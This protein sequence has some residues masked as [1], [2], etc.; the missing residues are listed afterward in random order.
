MAIES[1]VTAS[2]ES[3]AGLYVGTSGWSYPSW[4]PGFYP[5]GIDAREFL[6]FY[7]Q[8]FRTVELNTTGYR[9]P[10][11]EQFERWAAAD[12]ASPSSF[13]PS[14]RR[15]SPPST[16]GCGRSATGSGPSASQ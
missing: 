12:S 4:R 9:L 13:P 7:A 1:S 11:Q 14:G 8:R 3:L 6:S 5:A 15:S 10:A 2:S 16:S